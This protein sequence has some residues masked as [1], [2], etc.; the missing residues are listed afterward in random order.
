VEMLTGMAVTVVD[1]DEMWAL[2][3]KTGLEDSL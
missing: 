2:E 1:P 3:R